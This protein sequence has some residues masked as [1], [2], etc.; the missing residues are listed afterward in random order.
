[1]KGIY[2]YPI[3]SRNRTGVSNP[4][5]ERL[6]ESLSGHYHI[7]NKSDPSDRGILDIVK[8]LRRTDILYLNWVENLPTRHMGI[9]QT[10]FFF[11]LCGYCR[12]TGKKIVWTL[13]N[14]KSHSGDHRFLKNLLISFLLFRSNLVITHA[15]E[16]LDLIPGRTRKVC[17]PH[18]VGEIPPPGSSDPENGEREFDMIIWGTIAAYKGVDTFLSF[19]KEKGVLGNY[20]IVIAGKVAEPGLLHFLEDLAGSFD[21]LTLINRFIPDAELDDLIRRS[22]VVLF[23]YHAESVLSS[24]ALMDSLRHDSVILGPHTGA[25][26][27]LARA[28][29]IRT[30]RDYHDLLSQVDL[31]KKKGYREQYRS[32]LKQSFLR[33]NSWDRFYQKVSPHLSSLFAAKG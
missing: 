28:K 3:T 13:H 16:G 1:M 21:T 31:M 27:D 19:L 14:K 30:F 29:M 12:I 8:F 5:I 15:E 33:E 9:L 10:L 22:G 32:E 18:P 20:R 24:G 6:A 7:V 25:F 4:Y 11:L 2:L 23:T 17:V 26:T